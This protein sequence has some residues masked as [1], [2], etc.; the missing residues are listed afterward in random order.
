[1]RLGDGD[2]EAP[3]PLQE[4]ALLLDDLSGEVPGKD[5]EDVDGIAIQPFRS[6]NRD[7]GT[8]C[9]TALLQ[10]VAVD[11]VTDRARIDVARRQEGVPLRGRS[12]R[13]HRSPGG[14]F[15]PDRL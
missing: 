5:E 4:P 11:D 1:M 6:D 13:C 9:E 3:T 14:R 10:R 8:G 12:V 15:G 7:V 2:E